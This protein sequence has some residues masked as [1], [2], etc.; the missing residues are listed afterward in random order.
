MRFQKAQTSIRIS[1]ETN[2]LTH[3]NQIVKTQRIV[4]EKQIIEHKGVDNTAIR[5]SQQKP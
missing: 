5:I 1:W 2:I 4:K 3:Y